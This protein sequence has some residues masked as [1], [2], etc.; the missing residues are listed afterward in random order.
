MAAAAATVNFI[1]R[2]VAEELLVQIE[3]F[4]KGSTRALNERR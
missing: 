1:L 2:L 3:I 4:A